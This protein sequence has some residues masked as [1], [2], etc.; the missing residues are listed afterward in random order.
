MDKIE[1]WKIEDVIPYDKNPRKNENAVAYVAN[2]IREFGFRVPIVVD[3]NKVIINGH[4]RLKAAQSL[5]MT[6]VPVIV[7][8][9][10]T[11]DQARAYRIAD[12]KTADKAYWDEILLKDELFDL[13]DLFN[14][15]DFG[16]EDW[17]LGLD[18]DL[19][20]EPTKDLEETYKEPEIKKLRC[21]HCGEIDSASRFM[22][23]S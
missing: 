13:E 7:A 17:E 18:E 20:A 5:G 10:L 6:E 22:K 19:F 15:R 14:M 8:A 4:T 23:A 12:N 3:K 2:S 16:F 9:D 11:E 1:Y 21:P